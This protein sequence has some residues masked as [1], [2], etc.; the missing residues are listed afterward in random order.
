MYL[1]YYIVHSNFILQ[2]CLDKA[3]KKKHIMEFQLNIE[4]N[5]NHL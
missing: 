4:G 2:L 5:F 3:K 1:K